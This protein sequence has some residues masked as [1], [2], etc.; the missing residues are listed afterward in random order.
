MAK[1]EI[2]LGE[3]RQFYFHLKA[4]NGKII[5][6]SEAYHEK[7]GARNGI[8]SVHANAGSIAQFQLY[9]SLMNGQF[10]FTLR[11]PNNEVIGVSEMYASLPNAVEGIQT[12]KRV[13]TKAKEAVEV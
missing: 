8:D 9:E 12:V 1:F 10:Y 11:A 2:F 3:D 4:D 7:A 13:V 6:A 5:L